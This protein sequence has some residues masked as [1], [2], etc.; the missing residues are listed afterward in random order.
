MPYDILMLFHDGIPEFNLDAYLGQMRC[1]ALSH[2]LQTFKSISQK[3]SAP[4][5]SHDLCLVQQ[6]AARANI[7]GPIIFSTH[8]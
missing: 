1:V 3:Y 7:T 5:L 2:V 8:G 4:Q 6:A